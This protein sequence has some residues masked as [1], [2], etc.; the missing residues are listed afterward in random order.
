M[1]LHVHTLHTCIILCTSK[2][3]H[4]QLDNVPIIIR[5]RTLYVGMDYTKSYK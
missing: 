2:H 1:L 3:T 5:Q 4:M